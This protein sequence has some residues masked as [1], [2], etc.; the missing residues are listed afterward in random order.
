MN[1]Y[2]TPE[3]SHLSLNIQ[4]KLRMEWGIESMCVTPKATEKVMRKLHHAMIPYLGVN[5]KIR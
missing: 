5:R 2:L 4:L 1:R 3:D